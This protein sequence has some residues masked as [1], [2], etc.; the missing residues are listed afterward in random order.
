MKHSDNIGPNT[1]LR[2]PELNLFS[3]KI[4]KMVI[5]LVIKFILNTLKIIGKN[6]NIMNINK[7]CTRNFTPL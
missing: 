6:T 7:R 1:L 5:Y 3:V 4:I 2:A